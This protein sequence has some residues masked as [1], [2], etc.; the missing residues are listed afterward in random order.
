MTRGNLVRVT[1]WY[2]RKASIKWLL[3]DIYDS[4]KKNIA[5]VKKNKLD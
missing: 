3:K 1:Y 5:W 4:D 2:E